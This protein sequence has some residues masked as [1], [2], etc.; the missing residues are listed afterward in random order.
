MLLASHFLVCGRFALEIKR[1][2]VESNGDIVYLVSPL[3]GL[4]DH[5]SL[6]PLPNK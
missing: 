5:F 2:G 6:I 1:N 3:M 4:L